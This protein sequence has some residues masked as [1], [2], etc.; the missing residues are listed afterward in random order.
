MKEASPPVPTLTAAAGTTKAAGEGV[1]LFARWWHPQPSYIASIVV[2]GDRVRIFNCTLLMIAF[3]YS[4][5]TTQLAAGPSGAEHRRP[6]PP[7]FGVPF[8][9]HWKV[10]VGAR[11]WGLTAGGEKTEPG[12]KLLSP[13]DFLSA[14]RSFST[15]VKDGLPPVGVG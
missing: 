4:I 7:S 1:R 15:K 9:G 6:A 13:K 14:K 11:P 3:Q 5:N 8:A 10:F 12:P 2:I